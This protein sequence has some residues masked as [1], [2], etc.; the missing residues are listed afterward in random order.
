MSSDRSIT[1]KIIF[2]SVGGDDIGERYPT[3]P[4]VIFV[5]CV[6]GNHS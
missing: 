2:I 6:S 3:E 5:W 1:T 4:F